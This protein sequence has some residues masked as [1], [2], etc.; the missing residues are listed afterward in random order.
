MSNAREWSW[1]QLGIDDGGLPTHFPM[2]VNA[3][4]LGPVGDLRAHHYECWCPD[5]HCEITWALVQ[6]WLVGKRAGSQ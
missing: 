5:P 4:G 6:A 2:P 3:E 1:E